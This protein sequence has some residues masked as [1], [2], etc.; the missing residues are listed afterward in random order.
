LHAYICTN[1]KVVCGLK[2]WIVQ[3]SKGRKAKPGV[4]LPRTTGGEWQM[5]TGSTVRHIYILYIIYIYYIYY[6]LDQK[7]ELNSGW[8]LKSAVSLGKALE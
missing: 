4:K 8:I 7:H 3:A 6:L 5:E 1:N 2:L